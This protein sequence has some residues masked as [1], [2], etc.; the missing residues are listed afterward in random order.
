MDLSSAPAYSITH[1]SHPQGNSF[2]TQT[3]IETRSQVPTLLHR[4]RNIPHGPL[5]A[6][7][8]TSLEVSTHTRRIGSSLRSPSKDLIVDVGPGSYDTH[9]RSMHCP[10]YTFSLKYREERKEESPGPGGYAM[11]H[12][13]GR[14]TGVGK[15]GKSKKL[16][17]QV[18]ASPGPGA[19]NVGNE[20]LANHKGTKFTRSVRSGL[21]S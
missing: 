16:G 13:P 3:P 10:A 6:H 8:L 5:P 15:F 17:G 7:S 18:D 14:T 12:S 2:H 11:V 19:Y 9:L 20:E 4:T 1:K 21:E